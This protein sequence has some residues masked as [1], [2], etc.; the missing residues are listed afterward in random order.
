[1]PCAARASR[2]A[3]FGAEAEPEAS[4]VRIESGAVAT[5]RDVRHSSAFRSRVHTPLRKRK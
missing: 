3:R 2:F 4:V 1:M 5:R